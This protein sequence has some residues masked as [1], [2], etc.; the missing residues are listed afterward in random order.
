[1]Y[2]SGNL[3]GFWKLF[4]I[5]SDE[6]LPKLPEMISNYGI[7]TPLALNPRIDPYNKNIEEF[8]NVAPAY[9]SDF[10]AFIPIQNGCDKFCSFCAVPFTRGREV[11]R[12]SRDV[13]AEVALLISR[14]YKSITLLGQNVNSYGLD[15]QGQEILFPE[16]FVR[17]ASGDRIKRDSGSISLR[18]IHGT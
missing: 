4:D 13:L 11:S 14:G 10:E 17:L 2:S 9:Q 6:R 18:R 1:M 8:W 5:V 3:K 15:K 12:P 16:C 7:T